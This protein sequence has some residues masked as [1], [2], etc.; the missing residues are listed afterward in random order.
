MKIEPPTLGV[1]LA[2]GRARRM[3]G[4]DKPMLQ[5]GGRPMLA[6]VL[7]RLAPQCDA[8]IVSA[9]GDLTRFESF[10]A[11][12]VADGIGGFAGPLAGVLAA[13]EWA[14]TRRTGVEWV[15]SAPGDC[16]FLPR[17]LVARL[18]AARRGQ[19]AELAAAASGGRAHPAIGLWRVALREELRQ[20]LVVEHC[21]KV[22]DWTARYSLAT[23]TWP[24][25]PLDPFFNVNSPE[26]LVEAERLAIL[27]GD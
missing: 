8:L 22:A 13:L 9:N 25:E 7:A 6:R 26:D 27:D 1:V 17:D 21:R 24:S 5:V 16:P 4:R 11:P 3:G 14:A 20:A 19:G 18:H 23:A 12:V 15:V 2:G 10:G